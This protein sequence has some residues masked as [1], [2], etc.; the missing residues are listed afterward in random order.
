MLRTTECTSNDLLITKNI[1]F[2]GTYCKQGRGK[3][4]VI[5]IADNTFM[6]SIANASFGKIK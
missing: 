4:I 2:F 1:A 6:G 3:G 5:K